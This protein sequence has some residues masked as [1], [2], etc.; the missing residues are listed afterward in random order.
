MTPFGITERGFFMPFQFDLGYNH[1]FTNPLI[2]WIMKNQEC[3][4]FLLTLLIVFGSCQPSEDSTEKF[5]I[6]E[7]AKNGIY[8]LNQAS[9]GAKVY[10]SDCANCHGVDLRGTEGG[11]PLIGSQFLNKWKEQSMAA[12]LTY[13]ESTMPQSNPGSYDRETYVSLIA[14]ILQSNSFPP[15]KSALSTSLDSLTSIQIGSP[16]ESTLARKFTGRDL[17]EPIETIDWEWTQHRS[18]YASTNYAPLELVN[19]GNVKNLKILW[20]WK[21]DNFGPAPEEYFKVTPLMVG[22]VLYFTA[23]WRR[24]VVAADARTGET[25]WIYRIDEGERTR[26]SPRQ[27][28][29]RGVS[30]WRGENGES[31]RIIFITPGYQLIALNPENGQPISQFGK[32]G[33]V[34]LKTQLEGDIDL[35]KS[36]IGSTSPPIIVNDVIVVGS[37]FATGLAPPSRNQIPGDITAYDV[38]SG[39]RIWTFHTIPKEGEYGNE[40]W[41]NESWKYTGNVGAW[42]SFSADPELGLVYVPLEAAT[43]DFYGGHR[44]GD[45]LFSQSI[46]CL[47]IKSGKR[48]W[49]YQTVHHDIWDYDLPA[50]PILADIEVDGKQIKA[51]A[52]VTKQAFTFV[53][54]RTNGNPVWPI[55]ERQVPQSMI[56]GEKTSLT[57]PFP[58]KPAPFDEQEINDDLLI[59]FTPEIKQKAIEI[60]KNYHYG[61]LY[62]PISTPELPDKLGTLMLPGPTG[63]A[64]WQGAVLDPGSNF[65]YVS[66]TTLPRPLAMYTEPDVSDMDYVAGFAKSV[67]PGLGGPFGLPLLKPPWGRITAIDLNSGEHVWMIANGDSPD[68]LTNHPK[69]KGIELPRTGKPDRVGLL[70][71]KSLL[72]AGEGSGLYSA[73][74]GGGNMFRAHDKNTGEIL[75]EIELPAN[76]AGIPMTYA[77]NDKQYIVVAV[78]APGHPGE[79]IC[80]GL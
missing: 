72:F 20:R 68:W 17:I 80:L 26:F 15:G 51:L 45:N 1:I 41:E 9:F 31:D 30:Y 48:V 23:G 34:D 2:L 52:Q 32:Q 70:V 54:D 16:P 14:Y 66:S 60:A 76:Q 50:P 62:T 25:L 33:V 47:D 55:E 40:S 75:A 67:V 3:W 78:G 38:R 43:G 44:P 18:D 79:L 58:T 39:E 28:S 5:S 73:P 35:V 8:V 13:T 10:K 12:L 6:K 22:G 29:G 74:G 77:I 61:S 69:L 59:D 53:L 42:T 37:C 64:N 56:P 11:T 49:H 7:G 57:Q 21:S 71:T 36:A 24:T 27:N 4:L 19:K 46:V 65:M 63:G